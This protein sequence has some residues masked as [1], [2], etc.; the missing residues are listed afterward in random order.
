MKIFNQPSSASPVKSENSKAAKGAKGPPGRK[1]APPPERKQMSADEIKGKLAAHVEASA[2]PKKKVVESQKLGEG[3]LNEAVVRPPVIVPF[4]KD[5]AV[6]ATEEEVEK[7]KDIILKS[8]IA[9]NDPT[10][11]NTQEKLKTVLSKGAFN[12]NA[13]EKEALERILS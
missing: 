4:E 1:K 11:T 8:D 2:A 13:K 5:S 9:K 10:D 6:E 12:F 7:K 3:F